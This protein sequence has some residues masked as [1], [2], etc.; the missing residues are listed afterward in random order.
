LTIPVELRLQLIIKQPDPSGPTFFEVAFEIVELSKS[1]LLSE[2]PEMVDPKDSN[3]DR[4]SEIP[5]Y[6]IPSEALPGKS[7]I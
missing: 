7:L 3:M 4:F 1:H 2:P 6:K 5:S